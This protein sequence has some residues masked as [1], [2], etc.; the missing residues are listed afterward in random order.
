MDSKLLKHDYN[1]RRKVVEE[2]DNE[3]KP[4]GM[5]INQGLI[6]RLLKDQESGLGENYKQI[7]DYEYKVQG[8][9]KDLPE[10]SLPFDIEEMMEDVRGRHKRGE[11][12]DW[13]EKRIKKE[14]E[15]RRERRDFHDL[16]PGRKLLS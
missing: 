11:A 1:R 7:G 15:D 16:F 6:D 2:E 13:D 3:E 5:F 10:G 12:W 9:P 4:E 8:L 14:I